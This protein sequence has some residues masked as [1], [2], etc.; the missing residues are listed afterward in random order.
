MTAL[1]LPSPAP[2]L[3]RCSLNRYATEGVP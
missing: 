1:S 3:N 2:I